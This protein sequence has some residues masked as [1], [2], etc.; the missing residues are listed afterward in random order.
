MKRVRNVALISE[1]QKSGDTYLR[2]LVTRVT[3]L[4]RSARLR[5]QLS[6]VEQRSLELPRSY[7]DQLAELI[8]RE[9]DAIAASPNPVEYGSKD[10]N[11][12]MTSGLDIG[13]DR[14]RSENVQVRMRGLAL[15]LALVYSDTR[16]ANAQESRELHRGV[17]RIMREL[18]VFSSRNAGGQTRG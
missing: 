13:F 1:Y 3:N 10:E 5:R 17:M 11:G 2:R 15:W 14:A 4:G 12:S 6:E 8:G 16:D 9:C 7:R 18:K